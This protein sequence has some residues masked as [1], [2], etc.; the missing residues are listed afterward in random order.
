MMEK[1]AY[2][3]YSQ[4]NITRMLEW[5]VS[6]LYTKK[7]SISKYTHLKLQLG[8]LHVFF[9]SPNQIKCNASTFKSYSSYHKLGD[10]QVFVLF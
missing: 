5:M 8:V 3:W 6:I 4:R 10:V 2:C 7:K 9:L 1:L